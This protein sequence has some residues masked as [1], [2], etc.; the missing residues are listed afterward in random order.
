MK[1]TLRELITVAEELNTFMFEKEE[2]K[3][4]LND[5][6]EYAPLLAE[7]I[8]ICDELTSDDSVTLETANILKK[9]GLGY[10]FLPQIK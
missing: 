8:Q 7:I 9:M 5:K 3:I 6:L 4:N 10:G 2:E 1:A